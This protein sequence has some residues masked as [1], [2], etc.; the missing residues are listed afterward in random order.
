MEESRDRKSS[1]EILEKLRYG[2]ENTKHKAS[3]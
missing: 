2:I 1:N 3:I